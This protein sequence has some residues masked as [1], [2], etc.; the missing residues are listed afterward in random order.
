MAFTIVLQIYGTLILLFYV[1]DILLTRSTPTLVTSFIQLLS[2]EFTMKDLGLVHH[3][4]GIEIPQ[5]SSGLHLSQSHYAPTI[6]EWAAM[7]DCKPMSTPLEAK[8]KSSSHVIPLKDPSFFQEIVGS[9]NIS[10]L[11]VMIFLIVLIMFFNFCML[12]LLHI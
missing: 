1:D 8:T 5:T 12:L 9:Y 4:L 3:F 2:R 10:Y 11:H 6:L 7:V